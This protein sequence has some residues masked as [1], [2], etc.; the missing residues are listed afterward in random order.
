M[1]AAVG[2]PARAPEYRHYGDDT[3]MPGSVLTFFP[4]PDPQPA[5]R[6][7]D[8]IQ[9][10]AFAV[11]PVSRDFWKSHLHRCGVDTDQWIE[12][13][14]Q[15][16][17][18]FR[19][20]DGQR[21]KLVAVAGCE[22]RSYWQ[23][24]PLAAEHAIRGLQGIRLGVVDMEA[25]LDMLTGLLG[26]VPQGESSSVTRLT[27]AGTEHADRC[28]DV[29]GMAGV[30]PAPRLPLEGA[31]AMAG[32]TN[33]VAFRTMDEQSQREFRERLVNAG[34]MLT[35]VKDR[36]YFKSIYM[37]DP[38]GIRVEIATDGPGFTVDEPRDRLGGAL[39]LPPWLE[40][41]RPA[42]EVTL[43]A[44]ETMAGIAPPG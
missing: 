26:L 7:S 25:E 41:L 4:F 22:Q 35:P 30:P 31:P 32:T 37:I 19:D 10:I 28:V 21:L 9:E 12:E 29:E 16:V 6:G 15:D 33:H 44:I 43:P 17:L 14:G 2:Q 18:R 1:G 27:F 39:C 5:V 34:L 38:G 20:H 8:A 40:H 3:G 23:Q 36:R 24:G 11:P 13:F 42:Y